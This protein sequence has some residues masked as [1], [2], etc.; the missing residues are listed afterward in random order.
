MAIRL[1]RESENM[2]NF[3]RVDRRIISSAKLKATQN[4]DQ[5]NNQCILHIHTV[6]YNSPAKM[7]LVCNNSQSVIIREGRNRRMSQGSPDRVP[8]Y[9]YYSSAPL[10][11]S[12]MLALYK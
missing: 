6:G 5:N 12:D 3:L 7:F 10:K 8:T 2:I 11:S 4:N 1:E 9:S